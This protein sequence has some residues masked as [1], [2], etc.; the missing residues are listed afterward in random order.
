MESLALE[1]LCDEEVESLM[2]QLWLLEPKYLIGGVLAADETKIY[3]AYLESIS[4]KY[5]EKSLNVFYV[6]CNF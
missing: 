4:N 5:I 6:L 2:M 3:L 1:P